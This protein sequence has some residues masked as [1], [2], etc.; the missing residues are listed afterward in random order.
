MFRTRH[1]PVALSGVL[2]ILT[3]FASGC[4]TRG[5]VRSQVDGLRGDVDARTEAIDTRLAQTEAAAQEAQNDAQAALQL[6]EGATDIALGNVKYHEVESATVY[7]AFDSAELDDAARQTLN[8]VS[9]TIQQRP[10][11]LIGIYGYTD[12]SGSASYNDALGR[13]RAESVLRHLEAITPNQLSRYA[14][15]S[16]GETRPV[17]QGGGAKGQ[18]LNRRVV[19]SLVEKSPLQGKGS[20][21]AITDR[22]Q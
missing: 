2:L 16:Y 11:L 10:G 5:Y 4:A 6:S 14:I 13:R 15:L 21:E 12:A 9:S 18:D 7:F 20:S 17:D 22:A 1:L 19:V 8:R 3:A